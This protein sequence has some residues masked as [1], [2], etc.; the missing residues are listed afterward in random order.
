R[1]TDRRDVARPFL[2]QLREAR[3]ERHAHFLAGLS[4]ALGDVVARR[5]ELQR[6]RPRD[7]VEMPFADAAAPDERDAEP[8]GC[9]LDAHGMAR[10]LAAPA[11]S[12][13]RA[14]ARASALRESITIVARR[15]TR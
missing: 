2:E 10:Q 7:R 14:A 3:V 8:L 1:R 6:R 4:C 5:H 15:F 13:C 12:G 9:L 11:G